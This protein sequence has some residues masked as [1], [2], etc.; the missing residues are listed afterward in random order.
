MMSEEAPARAGPGRGRR[1]ALIFAAVIAAWMALVLFNGRAGPPPITCGAG[2]EPDR[3][4]VV[5]LSAS[6]CGYCR[7]ARA[8]LQDEGIRYCE[9]DIETSEE[10]RR[11]FASLPLKVIPVLA[12]RGDTLVGYNRTEIMQTLAAHGLAEFEN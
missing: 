7:R 11:R 10:G 4:T 8:F 1:P 12:I 6:W 5:M 3:D 9:Y 2:L